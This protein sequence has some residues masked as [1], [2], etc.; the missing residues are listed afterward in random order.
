MD[1]HQNGGDRCRR[2]TEKLA[3]QRLPGVSMIEIAPASTQ[4]RAV[5]PGLCL[6]DP[7]QGASVMARCG[8]GRRN[9]T[10]GKV[11]RL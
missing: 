8:A 2:S 10:K 3:R 4:F 5:V 7:S 9:V 11:N 1:E 6:Q